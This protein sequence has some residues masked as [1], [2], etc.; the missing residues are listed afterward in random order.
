MY[1]IEIDTQDG[2]HYAGPYSTRRRAEKAATRIGRDGYIWLDEDTK[3]EMIVITAIYNVEVQEV[4]AA[5]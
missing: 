5:P 3:E 2:L 1:R 4:P